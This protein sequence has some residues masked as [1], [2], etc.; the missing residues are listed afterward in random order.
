MSVGSRE[1]WRSAKS[2]FPKKVLGNRYQGWPGRKW[3]DIRRLGLLGPIM[4]SR[5]DVCAA[6][7]FDAIEPD[8]MDGYRNK[9]GC[10]PTYAGQLRYDTWLAEK[11][12]ER[13]ISPSP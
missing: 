5:T 13:E 12:H 9:T 3:L 10:S 8:N 6:K 4:G 1:N 11:A 7:G 2:R